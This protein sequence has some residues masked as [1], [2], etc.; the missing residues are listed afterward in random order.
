MKRVRKVADENTLKYFSVVLVSKNEEKNI[1]RCLSSLLGQAYPKKYL[2][3]I[4]VDFGSTDKTVQLARRFS[5]RFDSFKIYLL[6]DQCSDY[7]K[8]KNY[9]GAQINLGVEKS[10]GEIIFFPDID[11]TFERGLLLEI[12]KKMTRFDALFIPEDIVGSGFL[13][14]IRKFERSFYNQT[15]VDAIRVIKKSI[16]IKAGGYDEK[17]IVFG[18]DDWDFTKSVK[19]IT[20]KISTTQKHIYHHEEALD[21]K[22]FLNKKRKYVRC[23][24]GYVT[25]WGNDDPDVKKQLG[26]WYR[27]V[28]VFTEH[29]KW[30]KLISQPLTALAMYTVRF[31]TWINYLLAK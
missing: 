27:T 18:A 19:G 20:S 16:F 8:I 9:R 11:M 15:L 10:K 29:G 25:K 23:F 6:N 30:R 28:V 2:D 5:S 17:N 12:S 22:S 21:L 4:L 24:N 7:L 13:G 14:K 3:I 31:I 1:E 26:V